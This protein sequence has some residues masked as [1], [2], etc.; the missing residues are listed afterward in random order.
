VKLQIGCVNL[1]GFG[2]WRAGDN[3]RIQRLAASINQLKLSLVAL[4]ETW[5]RNNTEA[6]VIAR[7]IGTHWTMHSQCRTHICSISSYII[8]QFIQ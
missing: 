2:R 6:Q 5:I 8:N 7:H 3:S 1:G 4:S